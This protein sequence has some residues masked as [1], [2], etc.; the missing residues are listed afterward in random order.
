MFGRRRRAT[1]I[2]EGLKI[3][4]SVSAEGFVELHG[5][6]EGE[7]HCTSLQVS[8]RGKING[9]IIADDVVVN[10]KVDG[11]INGV[12]VNLQSKARVTGD[13]HHQLFSIEKGAFFAGRS[14]QKEQPLKEK[15]VKSLAAKD[16]NSRI[17]KGPAPKVRGAV[18]VAQDGA[19]ST[20]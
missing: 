16:G 8:E 13:I 19:P 17:H 20:A 9:K 12:Y 18:K 11:P 2:A 7:L 15:T 4:G 6:I 10:G 14:I 1:V 3:A 5:E